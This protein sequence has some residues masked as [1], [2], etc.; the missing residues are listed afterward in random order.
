LQQVINEME[1]FLVNVSVTAT[2]MNNMKTVM[3]KT[4]TIVNNAV[5]LA[6]QHHLCVPPAKQSYTDTLALDVS[7]VMVIPL[8]DQCLYQKFLLEFQSEV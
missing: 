4:V 3:N 1:E 6:F 5:L 2:M 7:S 8:K